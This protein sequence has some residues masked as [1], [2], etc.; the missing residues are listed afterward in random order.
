MLFKSKPVPIKHVIA[1][2]ALSADEVRTVRAYLLALA[3]TDDGRKKLEP[4]KLKGFA[5]YEQSE[6]MT[7]GKWLGL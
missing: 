2:P 7:L 3:D 1:G 4:T 5:A 6:M